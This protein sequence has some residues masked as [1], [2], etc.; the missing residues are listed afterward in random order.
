MPL[1]L[2]AFFRN[3]CNKFSTKDDILSIPHLVMIMQ[4]ST[5]RTFARTRNLLMK[6]M[7]L[8]ETFQQYLQPT[9]F[10]HAFNLI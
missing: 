10:L 5:M 7:N 9:Q 6:T 4:R 3:N 8:N 1:I 2:T